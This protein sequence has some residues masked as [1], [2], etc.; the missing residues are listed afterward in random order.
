[1]TKPLARPPVAPARATA[2][3]RRPGRG[4]PVERHGGG[5]Q[6]GAGEQAEVPAQA[7]QDQRE[8]EQ[9]DA[10]VRGRSRAAARA[11]QRDAAGRG[12]GPG[13]V[14][15]GEPP[16]TGEGRNIARCAGR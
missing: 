9:R 8:R 2:T 12:D 16:V 15:V 7:E 6:G 1:M 5:D 4:S 10:V 3:S 13:A 11:E 14:P